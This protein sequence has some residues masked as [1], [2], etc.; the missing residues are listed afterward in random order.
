M[1]T[2]EYHEAHV[3]PDERV[4]A[5]GGGRVQV[6]EVLQVGPDLRIRYVVIKGER[7]AA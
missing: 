4:E 7:R 5:G 1:I 2:I 3:P 6:L